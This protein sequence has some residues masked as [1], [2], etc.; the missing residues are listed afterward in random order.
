MTT[1]KEQP[2]SLPLLRSA[3]LTQFS[4]DQLKL[5]SVWLG[6]ESLERKSDDIFNLS[7]DF[8]K[9]TDLESVY[10]DSNLL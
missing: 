7:K 2:L 10:H 6:Y 1:H 8:I 5:L 3:M 4:D 9:L